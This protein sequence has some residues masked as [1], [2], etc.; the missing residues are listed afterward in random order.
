MSMLKEVAP[1][2][3][4]TSLCSQYWN[5]KLKNCWWA[6]LIARASK[7]SN[8]APMTT[9]FCLNTLSRVVRTSIPHNKL[10]ITVVMWRDPGSWKSHHQIPRKSLENTTRPYPNSKYRAL[11]EGEFQDDSTLQVEPIHIIELRFLHPTSFVQKI[12]TKILE[13]Q[14]AKFVHKKLAQFVLREGFRS[15]QPWG[16]LQSHSWLAQC[17]TFLGTAAW[18]FFRWL[19]QALKGECNLDQF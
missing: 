1:D 17:G 3:Y 13:K 12:S 15:H 8:I 6:W 7:Y 9:A 4:P 5:E 11:F 14:S 19:P 16:R 18:I 2:M 10:M